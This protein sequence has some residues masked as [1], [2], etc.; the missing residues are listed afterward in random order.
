MR[1]RAPTGAAPTPV[2][3]ARDPAR[4][5][6]ELLD[7]LC[8]DPAWVD[9]T[10]WEIVAADRADPPGGDPPALSARPRRS[11]RRQRATTRRPGVGRSQWAAHPRGRQRSPPGAPAGH[12]V[13]TGSTTGSRRARPPG[14]DG[15]DHRWRVSAGRRPSR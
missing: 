14:L 10:F 11:S 6:D 7:L 15:L 13:P 1:S 5:D 8:A 9:E 4:V 12:R 2:A 3:P